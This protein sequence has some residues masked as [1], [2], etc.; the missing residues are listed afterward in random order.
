MPEATIA[1]VCWLA[2]FA[3]LVEQWEPHHP[4][5]SGRQPIRGGTLSL[6]Q[7]LS[8]LVLFH[9]SPYKDFKH[10][11]RYGLTQEYRACLGL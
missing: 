6:A 9:I 5:P 2:D 1:L 10:V 7:M 8:I 11:W 4:L 3:T